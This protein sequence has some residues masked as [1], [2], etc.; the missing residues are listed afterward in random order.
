MTRPDFTFE[1]C[2]LNIVQSAAMLSDLNRA[3]KVLRDL[4][5]NECSLKFL[6]MKFKRSMLMELSDASYANLKNGA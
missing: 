3:N 5:A 1:C 6:V 2:Q 4:Q